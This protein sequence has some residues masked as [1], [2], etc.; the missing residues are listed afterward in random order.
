MNRIR[1]HQSITMSSV[2][3][4]EEVIATD[5]AA[6]LLMTALSALV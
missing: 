3:V 2:K 4:R 1:E 5:S 6:T